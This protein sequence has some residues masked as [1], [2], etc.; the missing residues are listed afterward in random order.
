MSEILGM[1]FNRKNVSHKTKISYNE[2]AR[3]YKCMEKP[4]F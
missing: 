4:V 1:V 2:I 3:T